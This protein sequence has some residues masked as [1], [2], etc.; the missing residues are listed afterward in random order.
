MVKN[1]PANAEDS[2]D[3]CLISGL[4]RSRGQGQ[5][6]PLRYSPLE[7]PMEREVCWDTVHGVA[8]SWTLSKQFNMHMQFNLLRKKKAIKTKKL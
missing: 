8:K 1:P 6:N 7:N 3:V 5:G 4:G 2:R